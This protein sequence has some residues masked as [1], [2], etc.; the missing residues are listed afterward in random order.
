MPLR[1]DRSGPAVS[2]D[3]SR[4]QSQETLFGLPATSEA[5][6]GVIEN[7]SR[8]PIEIPPG[9]FVTYDLETIDILKA[10][11]QKAASRLEAF[12]RYYEGFRELRGVRPTAVEAFHDGYNPRAIRQ[13]AGS[14]LSFV[15]GSGGLTPEQTSALEHHGKFLDELESTPMTKSYKMLVLQAM[16]NEDRFPG[17][18]PVDALGEAVM[19]IA[20]RNRQLRDDLGP[21]ADTPEGLREHLETNPINAWTGGLGTGGTAYFAYQNGVFRTAFP[22]DAADRIPLRELTREL[23]DWRLADYLDRTDRA[24]GDAATYV[25]KVSHANGRPILFLDRAKNPSLPEGTT[26]VDIDGV[27][28]EADFVKIALNVVRK[29]GS[30]ENRLP[31]ILRAWFGSDAGRPGTRHQVAVD[32]KAGTW[33]LCPLGRANG[34][35]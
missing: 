2:R 1:A 31:D 20:S 13:Q 3:P 22:I 12:K 8:G 33:L 26:L 29:P 30:P 28:H 4:P 25:C 9:C 11:A 14:W 18:I 19:A 10:L 24:N 5:V 17:E 15:R 21:K 16:L 35:R 32:N 27:P 7:A 6:I 34:S 23:V